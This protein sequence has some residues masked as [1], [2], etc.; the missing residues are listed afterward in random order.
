MKRIANKNQKSLTVENLSLKLFFQ[1]EFIIEQEKG[2]PIHKQLHN[3]SYV[4]IFACLSGSITIKT[5]DSGE[6]DLYAGDVALVPCAVEHFK[7]PETSSDTEWFGFGFVYRE[8]QNDG[9]NDIYSFFDGL[10]EYESVLIYK[11]VPSLCNAIKECHINRYNSEIHSILSLLS[12]LIKLPKGE[13]LLK[14]D[15]DSNTQKSKNIERLLMLDEIIN[16]KFHENFT[17]KDIAALLYI[18][19]RHLSRIVY[20]NYSEHLHTIILKKRLDVA[21]ELLIT[22]QDSVESIALSVGFKNKNSFHREFKK[23]FGMTPKEYRKQT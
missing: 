10:M 19:E 17:N 6:F 18:S 11:K 15:T 3:H 13:K 21:L 12:E 8:V 22:G 16:T 2:L 7:V 20:E 1:D 14:D 5:V 9:E 23:R 4:E